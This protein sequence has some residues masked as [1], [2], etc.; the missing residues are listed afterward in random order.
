MFLI[1]FQIRLAAADVDFDVQ[2]SEYL[3][4]QMQQ[5]STLYSYCYRNEEVHAQQF[6]TNFTLIIFIMLKQYK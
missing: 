6:Y 5:W 4:L 3:E 2:E 1:T